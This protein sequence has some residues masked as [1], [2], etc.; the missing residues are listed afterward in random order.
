MLDWITASFSVLFLVFFWQ[1]LH[2]PGKHSA[3]ELNP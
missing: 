1:D 3:T 2:T